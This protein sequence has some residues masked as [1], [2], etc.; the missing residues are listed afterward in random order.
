MVI[1]ADNQIGLGVQ[2]TGQYDLV[3]RV[4][5]HGASD[6]GNTGYQ[7]G[8]LLQQ[9]DERVD[10]LFSNGVFAANTRVSERGTDLCNNGR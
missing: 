2:S 8:V 4:G 5:R 1:S 9:S 7:K 10:V 3:C 6:V